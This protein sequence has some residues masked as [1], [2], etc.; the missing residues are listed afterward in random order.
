LEPLILLQGVREVTELVSPAEPTAATQRAF[1]A[2]RSGSTGAANLPAARQISAKLRMPWRDVLVLAHEPDVRHAHVLGLRG[3]EWSPEGW[4]TVD[5]ARFAVRLVAGRRRTV[6]LTMGAYE[7]ERL[8]LLA[9][10]RRDWL[11]GRRLRLPSATALRLAAGGWDPALTLAGLATDVNPP[12]T[13]TQTILSRLDVMDRFYD[14]YGEQPTKRALEAF[15][16]GNG[17]PMSDENKRLWSETVK[18]W[19]QRRRERGLPEPRVGARK[20]GRG[21][22][23]PDYSADVG[24]ACSGEQPHRGKWADAEACVAWVAR[25]LATLGPSERSTQDGYRRWAS[26]HPDAPSPS[27]FAR[28]GGWEAVRR[29]TQEDRELAPGRIAFHGHELN[30]QMAAPTKDQV[31]AEGKRALELLED[32]S[33]SD[34]KVLAHLITLLENVKIGS[35]LISADRDDKRLPDEVGKLANAAVLPLLSALEKYEKEGTAIDA[36]LVE[37]FSVALVDAEKSR[38]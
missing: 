16:R 3:R 1:D 4:L 11:H 9:E 13:I 15:A 7:A 25:Y 36:K 10:D 29:A 17:I 21:A 26:Q 33:Y 30:S 20:G 24:A 19:R 34:K 37:D 38:G 2:A 28:H 22:K 27:R 12:Q 23:A 14:H 8:A 31:I 35:E 5:R 32:D 18:L 6:T